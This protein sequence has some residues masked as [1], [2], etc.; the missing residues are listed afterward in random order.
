MNDRSAVLAALK[1]AAPELRRRWPIRALGVFGSYARGDIGPDSDVDVLVEFDR[2]IALS[3][4]LAIER[5]LCAAAGRPIDLVSRA[6]LNPA[7][8]RR[9]LRDLI[10]L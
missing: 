10:P 5:D 1:A 9:A 2:P 6:A 4:F 7:V 8:E 3:A